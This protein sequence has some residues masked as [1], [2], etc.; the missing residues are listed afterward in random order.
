MKLE[1]DNNSG[2]HISHYSSDRI[3]IDEKVYE[4]SVIV[5]PT[6]IVSP[7]PVESIVALTE[8]DYESFLRYK[9]EI[10]LFGSGTQVILPP[11]RLLGWFG[12]RRIGVEVMTTSAACRTYNLLAGEGRKVVAGLII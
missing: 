11:S 10:I 8:A 7:W 4:Q 1:L 6:V 12:E 5:T 3:T 9:P 2:H